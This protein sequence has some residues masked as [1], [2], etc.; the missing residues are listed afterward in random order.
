[1]ENP[2]WEWPVSIPVMSLQ[3]TEAAF[4]FQG[5][6]PF[7]DRDANIAVWLAET[8][9]G[10]GL[11]G[12]DSV[13]LATYFTNDELLNLMG[14]EDKVRT[15]HS[16]S[17]QQI[18]FVAEQAMENEAIFLRDGHRNIFPLVNWKDDKLFW[19]GI[20]WKPEKSKFIPYIFNVKEISR[21]WNPGNRLFSRI[22]NWL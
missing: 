14:G 12:A 15:L 4:S 21:G 17:P 11:S 2:R 19:I 20:N 13:D 16:F 7:C 6:S 9:P 18:R 10:T 3:R 1:M 22:P 8:F 5:G